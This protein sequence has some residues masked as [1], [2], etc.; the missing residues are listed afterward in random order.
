MNRKMA[1][2]E[3]S[4]QN[5]CLACRVKFLAL[6]KPGVTVH[7]QIQMPEGQ[8]QKNHEFKVILGY[9]LRSSSLG[10]L[11]P[12]LN[13]SNSKINTKNKEERGGGGEGRKQEPWLRM[14]CS[15]KLPFLFLLFPGLPQWRGN[16]G[17]GSTDFRR[18]AKQKL[19]A[20][21]RVIG[22]HKWLAVKWK[23]ER[24][25]THFR[26]CRS[27]PTNRNF[28]D[29]LIKKETMQGWEKTCSIPSYPS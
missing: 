21:C 7:S 23:G 5:D 26:P 29:S 24:W 14:L 4:R 25:K 16:G 22:I 12:C 27:C 13:S 15:D 8:K 9:L 11:R 19:W 17:T 20:I 6:L 28:I 3:L 2:K 1:G 10:C 18:A